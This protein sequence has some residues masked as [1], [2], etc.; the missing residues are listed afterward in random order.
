MLV[1]VSFGLVGLFY[2]LDLFVLVLVLVLVLVV[3]VVLFLVLR[4]VAMRCDA[5]VVVASTRNVLI[6]FLV[7]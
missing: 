7:R 3:D 2:Y 5:M 6:R 1:G 4:C